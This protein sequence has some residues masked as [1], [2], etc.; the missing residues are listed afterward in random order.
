MPVNSEEMKT[1]TTRMICQLTPMAAFPWK[2]TRWP[3]STWSTMPWSPPMMLVSM[4]GHAI[5]Q[6]AGRSGPS[7]M[8]L[9]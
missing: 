7:T 9:S 1:I 5:F 6:R 8:D 2:P 3:T 4:V